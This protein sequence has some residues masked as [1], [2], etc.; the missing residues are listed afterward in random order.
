MRT[1]G[2]AVNKLGGLQGGAALQ[3]CAAR[4]TRHSLP[5][6]ARP[7]TP[8]KARWAAH[9]LSGPTQKAHKICN[10]DDSRS[11]HSEGM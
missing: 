7:C 9:S 6:R 10:A 1:S 11:G 8:H 4:D 3:A 2:G 5:V